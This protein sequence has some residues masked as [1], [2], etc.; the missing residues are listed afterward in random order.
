MPPQ[1]QID[2]NTGERINSVVAG[3]QIDPATGERIKALPAPNATGLAN[4]ELNR[5][6]PGL[7]VSGKEFNPKT[8]VP[9][10]K[11]GMGGPLVQGATVGVGTDIANALTEAGQAEAAKPTWERLAEEMPGATLAH[12]VLHP[13]DTTKSLLAPFRQAG[14]QI[15]ES[16]NAARA[17]EPYTAATKGTEGA[18]NT[19]A[20]LTLAKAGEGVRPEITGAG[21]KAIAT[22]PVRGAAKLVNKVI[23]NPNVKDIA[24]AGG[25]LTGSALGHPF[26]GYLAGRAVQKGFRFPGEEFGL[27]KV[28]PVE[29]E[30]AL[31]GVS[32]ADADITAKNLGYPRGAKQAEEALGS[33]VWQQI[34]NPAN[35]KKA[36][37]VTP[38]RPRP[39]PV[40]A[41]P[42]PQA[43]L[44]RPALPPHTEP[45]AA[46]PVPPEPEGPIARPAKAIV[47][48]G[49]G[50]RMTKQFLT[51]TAEE[52]EGVRPLAAPPEPVWTGPTSPVPGKEPLV[53]PAE[54]K[55]EAAT[56][57][58][59]NVP[60]GRGTPGTKITN[61]QGE[62]FQA[63]KDGSWQLVPKAAKPLVEPANYSP[64]EIAYNEAFKAHNQNPSPETFQKKQEAGAAL[65][66]AL[67]EKYGE[68]IRISLEKWQNEIP[69]V[70]YHSSNSPNLEESG[71][72]TDFNPGRHQMGLKGKI[73]LADTPEA[74]SAYGG[75]YIYEVR[76][77]ERAL[78]EPDP[79]ILP[80]EK[81]GKPVKG[82]YSSV[83][84]NANIPKESIKN[85]GVAP[86]ENL[87]H[88][89]PVE[90]T[91][92]L[93]PYQQ[94][95]IEQ[96]EANTARF[97]AA[98]ESEEMRQQGAEQT[99]AGAPEKQL[100]KIVVR[101][102]ERT[103]PPP[104]KYT[105]T[106]GVTIPPG[107]LSNVVRAPGKLKPSQ[108]K[109]PATPPA[110]TTVP[111]TAEETT[112]LLQK[113]VEQA[114]GK[115]LV[116]P[117]TKNTPTFETTTNVRPSE[118]KA[119]QNAFNFVKE[120]YPELLTKPNKIILH[121]G[122]VTDQAG[123]FYRDKGI[124]HIY[125]QHYGNKLWGL[126]KEDGYVN[127][128]VHELTHAYK[129]SDETVAYDAGNRAQA[130]YQ[131][132]N[133]KK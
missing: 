112:A 42:E 45:I 23:A 116:E 83:M 3:I 10:P 72:T 19:A 21:V 9:Q 11:Y 106:P 92:P 7:Q 96:G 100:A 26:L 66:K 74:A 125:V 107:E 67:P 97:A 30:E 40:A 101:Q 104:V 84:Y 76:V 114:K 117:A 8:A 46:G 73:Y 6:H 41:A 16:V 31:G 54:F 56:G 33:K 22:S 62:T 53:T 20:L 43:D 50:G 44:T 2:P 123:G 127:A 115:K 122:G 132:L 14:S 64:E 105:P 95:R 52:G 87:A 129:T 81:P 98:K 65:E 124:V 126:T 49:P 128:L 75:K 15:A 88:N 13:I 12:S 103:N 91:K 59:G 5:E 120:Q 78:L 18:A 70:F 71:L 79:E 17:D 94:N 1:V 47:I 51:G 35:E 86:T 60:K 29:G 27:P 113:S 38:V 37:L 118:V 57:E 68:P 93:T 109:V 89:A 32:A 80:E 130:L 48:R 24:P 39:A 111:K 102:R 85:L 25:L 4:I 99:E 121:R 110:G 69:K 90:E 61:K 36:P 77:P 34:L 63:Q 131:K 55:T 28:A 58:V 82:D 133:K 119:F 108:L